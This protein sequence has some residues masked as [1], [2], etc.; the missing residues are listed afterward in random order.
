MIQTFDMRGDTAVM[1]DENSNA[2]IRVDDL[3]GDPKLK[4]LDATA[5]CNKVKMSGNTVTTIV[6]TGAVRIY[7]LGSGSMRELTEAPLITKADYD[8]AVSAIR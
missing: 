3:F 7:D 1:Y 5:R 2:L 6:D 8:R 4:D